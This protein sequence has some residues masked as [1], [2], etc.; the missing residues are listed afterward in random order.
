MMF[1]N[2]MWVFPTYVN[3]VQQQYMSC[4]PLSISI[5]LKV[6]GKNTLSGSSV[7]SLLKKGL[8]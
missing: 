7:A 2:S 5:P 6:R 8:L 3:D 1:R 4:L